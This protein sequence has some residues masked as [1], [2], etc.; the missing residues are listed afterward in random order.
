MDSKG[1][2]RGR[3]SQRTILV[4]SVIVMSIITVITLMAVVAG[5]TRFSSGPGKRS[6]PALPIA[7]PAELGE[8]VRP[9]SVGAP[10][11]SA[12]EPA[13]SPLAAA[14]LPAPGPAVVRVHVF[15]AADGGPV[16]GAE[17]VLG[18]DRRPST[19]KLVATADADGVAWFELPP[20]AVL[21]Q[22]RIRRGQTH[23]AI[24]KWL[25]GEMVP[26][27]EVIDLEI[28]VRSGGLLRGRVVHGEAPVP[29]A[30]VLAW[31]SGS[32]RGEPEFVLTADN[33]GRFE[34]PALGDA[35][36]LSAHTAALACQYGL[37]GSSANGEVAEGLEIALVEAWTLVGSIETSEGE[38]AAGIEV[39]V[40]S[41]VNSQSSLDGTSFATIL[42]YSAAR[43]V[44]TSGPDGTF[45]ISGLP[46]GDCA[47]GGHYPP[48]L[49]FRAIV[50]PED[51][52]VRIVL[53]AGRSLRGIVLDAAGSAAAGASVRWGPYYANLHSSRNPVEC[54]AD[55]RF[56]IAG[57]SEEHGLWV[58]II[59]PGHALL[60][61]EVLPASQ[62]R[63]AESALPEEAIVL[64][65][66]PEAR[67]AGV[68]L[69]RA[70]TPA[71]DAKVEIIGDR[72]IETESRT[73]EYPAS[74]WEFLARRHQVRT[75]ADGRFEFAG[76][77]PGEFEV[78][79][80]HPADSEKKVTVRAE[81][82]GPDLVIVLDPDLLPGVVIR[83]AVREAATGRPIPEF[84]IVPMIAGMGVHRTFA[85][86][87]GRFEIAGLDPGEISLTIEAAGYA[88]QSTAAAD[89]E[90]GDHE[91]DI[92]LHPSRVL[93]IA[94][95]GRG[96]RSGKL[97]VIG[98]GGAEI[99][100]SSGRLRTSPLTLAVD[101]LRIS[102]LPAT[103][104]QLVLDEFGP[105]SIRRDMDLS[106]DRV[107]EAV[108]D[109]AA[110]ESPR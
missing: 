23:A 57:L 64:H 105:L 45:A 89:Y 30:T 22:L 49:A 65:L 61:E 80:F 40:E 106:A 9:A 71:A 73:S 27:G 85:D 96:D 11:P 19:P 15:H 48:Y 100:L 77:Y 54:G 90:I 84:Q 76:L 18:I 60:V 20:S 103:R 46:W 53:D 101:R 1:S 94:L 38:P 13:A 17:V 93:E 12:A 47:I 72:I 88:P 34:I 3:V 52:P 7:P 75:G 14:P 41:G 43:G 33:S 26:A 81:S 86:E 4:T 58:A 78:R 35:F 44:A 2:D 66:E 92:D 63:R 10:A 67:I 107:H 56:E 102:D 42:R 51:G 104:L 68:V 97:R 79:A 87:H 25:G 8:P 16:P 28:A 29:H 39:R 50:T 70:G 36:L 109:L 31:F 5:V 24:E 55:G 74:T 6:L 69:A 98:P 99:L 91:V 32:D 110:D 95:L 21:W 62:A 37:R 82:G 108:F 59:H 83:G